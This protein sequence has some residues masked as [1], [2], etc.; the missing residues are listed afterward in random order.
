MVTGENRICYKMLTNAE[1]LK[2][3]IKEQDKAENERQQS[4]PL[5]IAKANNNQHKFTQKI[6]KIAYKLTA[7]PHSIDPI[8]N[9]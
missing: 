2:T 9:L 6:I 8:I 3:R 1:H 4:I 5:E 7:Y